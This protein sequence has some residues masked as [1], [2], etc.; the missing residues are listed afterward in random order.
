MALIV[1]FDINLDHR[2]GTIKIVRGEPH[3]K[4]PNHYWYTYDAYTDKR[5]AYHGKVL[6]N[7]DNGFMALTSKVTKAIVAEQ[8]A[9]RKAS[10]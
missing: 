5:E 4:L 6:H 10:R 8:K 1:R 9:A 3:T 7:Y 2:A